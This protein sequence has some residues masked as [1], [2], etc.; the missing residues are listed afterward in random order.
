MRVRNLFISF[1][2]AI[3]QKVIFPLNLIII[4]TY[5]I[6]L[7]GLSRLARGIRRLTGKGNVQERQGPIAGLFSSGLWAVPVSLGA[8]AGLPAVRDSIL[9][10]I[11]KIPFDIIMFGISN[12]IIFTLIFFILFSLV[13]FSF[14]PKPPLLKPR[15]QERP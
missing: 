10:L 13:I 8:V 5:L 12:R 6:L 9:S 15:I 14:Q 4:G 7:P 1:Y 2:S 3:I 11:S